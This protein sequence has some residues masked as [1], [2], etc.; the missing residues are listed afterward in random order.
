[1]I[2]DIILTSLLLI[3]LRRKLS[4][5]K[6]HYF[7]LFEEFCVFYLIVF[8][9][10]CG[11]LLLLS[12]IELYQY[13]K[14]LRLDAL[15]DYNDCLTKFNESNYSSI[16]DRCMIANMT[17]NSDIWSNIYN[18]LI[19]RFCSAYYNYDT[20]E[21]IIILFIVSYNIILLS[22]RLYIILLNYT[23][24]IRS[25]HLDEHIKT[26]EQQDESLKFIKKQ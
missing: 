26:R 1:M 10:R 5:N 18:E 8:C 11:V 13:E 19:S 2:I 25:K 6:Y 7:T 16:K 21:Y 24:T 4:N 22:E 3:V 9:M 23:Y 15:S 17:L 14:D 12:S 20:T